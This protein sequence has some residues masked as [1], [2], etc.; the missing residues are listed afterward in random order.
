MLKTIVAF[1]CVMMIAACPIVYIV[2]LTSPASGENVRKLY[3][4]APELI[5]YDIAREIKKNH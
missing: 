5:K 1:V 4:S 2:H 3:D